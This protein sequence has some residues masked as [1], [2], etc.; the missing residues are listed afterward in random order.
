M[1]ANAIEL[2]RGDLVTVS[3]PGDYGKPR[4]GLVI[5]SDDFSSLPSLTV[6]PLTSTLFDMP[7]LRLTILPDGA[8]GLR[9]PSQIMIDRV[10][11]LPR[12]KVGRFIGRI[13]PKSVEEAYRALM[14]FLAK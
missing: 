1:I 12:A 14:R 10:A 5:Q 7:L 6:L 11:S 8:N 3:L 9:R 2:R 13:D 4:P